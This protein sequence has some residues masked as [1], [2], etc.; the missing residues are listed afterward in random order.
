MNYRKAAWKENKKW[1]RFPPPIKHDFL[2]VWIQFGGHS[3]IKNQY[4]R[5]FN[6]SLFSTATSHSSRLFSLLFRL[7]FSLSHH[8]QF[9]YFQL[10]LCAYSIVYLLRLLFSR[11]YIILV[12]SQ[13]YDHI[14]PHSIQHDNGRE[15][16]SK[17]FDGLFKALGVKVAKIQPNRPQGD[18][19]VERTVRSLRVK[20]MKQL[21]HCDRAK[22]FPSLAKLFAIPEGR[23]ITRSEFIWIYRHHLYLQ[24]LILFCLTK[25]SSSTKNWQPSMIWT[26]WSFGNSCY[27]HVWQWKTIR[28]IDL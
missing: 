25:H 3:S 10:L 22:M 1:E 18:G 2:L 17:N 14:A 26:K 23:L 13:P 7:F 27:T 11:L 15:F 19:M 21:L 28:N 9:D 12:F 24:M 8:V 16:I 4:W 20:L 5:N 6:E